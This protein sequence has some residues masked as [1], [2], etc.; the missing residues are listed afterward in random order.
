MNPS[1]EN[2]LFLHASSVVVGGGALLFLGHSGAG[3]STIASLLGTTHPILADDSVFASSDPSG[4]WRVR[5]GKFSLDESIIHSWE[6]AVRRRSA[7]GPAIPVLGCLRIHKARHVKVA[8]LAP[9]ETARYLMAAVMEVD[10]QG[11]LNRLQKRAEHEKYKVARVRKMRLHWFC[12]A[13]ELAR[14]YPGWHLWFPKD[15]HCPDLLNAVFS[16]AAEAR[17]QIG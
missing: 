6:E 12:L 9:V 5:D 15:A 4:I 11:K 7:D 14:L 3:K 2:G 10:L 17:R 1:F 16:V 8:R 13:S